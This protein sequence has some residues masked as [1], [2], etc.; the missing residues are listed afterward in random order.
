M[1]S[2]GRD[3][4]QVAKSQDAVLESFGTKEPELETT[5]IPAVKTILD[6]SEYTT[7]SALLPPWARPFLHLFPVHI[8][9]SLALERF[10]T[11]A[12]AA[13]ARRL[14]MSSDKIDLLSKMVEVTDDGGRPMGNRELSAEATTLLAAGSDT[15]SK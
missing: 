4:V 10:G 11:V 15:I 12:A 6:R 5:E 2:S 13:I 1:T 3:V 7:A 14:L 8:R 9:G